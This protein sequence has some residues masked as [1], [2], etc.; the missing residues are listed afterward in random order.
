MTTTL[1]D[2][3][4]CFHETCVSRDAFVRGLPSINL[5][6]GRSTVALLR[7][8]EGEPIGTSKD[9]GPNKRDLVRVIV[10]VPG[11]RCNPV[12]IV[13]VGVGGIAKCTGC[14]YRS[15]S[16]GTPAT[17][18]ATVKKKAVSPQRKRRSKKSGHA[19]SGCE[20]LMAL[21]SYYRMEAHTEAV[22]YTTGAPDD[23]GTRGVLSRLVEAGGSAPSKRAFDTT[24]SCWHFESLSRTNEMHNERK[25]SQVHTPVEL[26]AK[27]MTSPSTSQYPRQLERECWPIGVCVA[28][29]RLYHPPLLPPG[30][31][32]TPTLT[33]CALRVHAT[34]LPPPPPPYAITRATPRSLSDACIGGRLW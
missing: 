24:T 7:N 4:T 13:T 8:R 19:E 11:I 21:R 29:A 9:R 2:G 23:D 16:L 26:E 34:P 25:H 31:A 1:Q 30:S 20:H 27:Q 33:A 3:G 32:P 28:C 12:A 10:G 18:A 5:S 6:S 22:D 17:R 14:E 15:L